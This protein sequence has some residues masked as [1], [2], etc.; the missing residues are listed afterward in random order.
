[1]SPPTL[2]HLTPTTTSLLPH[3][4]SISISPTS[5]LVISHTSLR[6]QISSSTSSNLK[7]D[8]KWCERNEDVIRSL[9]YLP[10][11]KLPQGS[12]V[13]VLPSPP[14]NNKDDISEY[15]LIKSLCIENQTNDEFER[16][17]IILVDFSSSEE[18]GIEVFKHMREVD[19]GS[20]VEF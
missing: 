6:S 15:S 7:A 1:M 3:L 9:G 8:I 2:L 4:S 18:K 5:T 20:I 16:Y 17:E 11:F 12:T 14:I 19:D 10:Q 13:I